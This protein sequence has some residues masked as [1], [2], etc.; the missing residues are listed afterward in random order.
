MGQLS[1]KEILEANLT[2]WRLLRN[3]LHARFATGSFKT[4]AALVAAITEVAE[5]AN[6]HPDIT[7]TYPWLDLRLI[8][9][10]VGAIT[11]RDVALAGRI[12]QIA[13]QMGVAG[14]PRNLVQLNLALDSARFDTVGRFWAVV[15]TG[16][17]ES[18]DK[19]QVVDPNG[20]VP[21]LWLQTTDVHAE[22]RQRFHLDLWVAPEQ[23]EARI[24]AAVAAGG[25][26]VSDA[27]KPAFVVL[28]DPEGNKVCLCTTAPDAG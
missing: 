10:D 21:L 22:P 20:R 2:D 11:D 24:E 23:L 14:D 17:A 4:G 27:Q 18:F 26:L 6:H 19:E 15:L 25:V 13:E 28:A 7:L 9:H 3:E 8:S 1:V 16:S 12:S 5:A